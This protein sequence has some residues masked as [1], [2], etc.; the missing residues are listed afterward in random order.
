MKSKLISVLTLAILLPILGFAQQRDSP[1]NLLPYA[2]FKGNPNTK[3]VVLRVLG[4]S[5]Q[6]GEIPAHTGASAYSHL[7]SVYRNNVKGS[8]AEIDDLLQALGYSGFNDP[9]F[10]A[11]SLLPEILPAGTIGWMGAYNRKHKYAW[12]SLGKAFPTFKIYSKGG[13]CFLYIMKKCG[14]AFY[15]PTYDTTPQCPA[16]LSPCPCPAG[17]RC[18][19]NG[20]CELIPPPPTACKTQTINISGTGQVSSGDVMSTS[21]SMELIAVNTS[22][23]GTKGLLLGS[24]PVSVRSIYDFNVKGEAKYSKNVE[25]CVLATET[26][27]PMNFALPMNLNYKITKNEVVV[28][29]GEK[30]YLNVDDAQFA[31]LSKAYKAVNVATTSSPNLE[32]ATKKVTGS[33]AT[34]SVQSASGGTQCADQKINF[35]GK[36]QVQ[37]G[38]VK[39]ATN[40][41]TIIGVYKKAGKLDKGETPEKYLCLGSFQVP[42]K[43]AYEFT[44]SGGSDVSKLVR[45]C[46][47]DGVTPADMNIN[48]PVNMTYN[49][50]KQDVVLGDYNKLYVQLNEKQYKSLSK[51]YNRCCTVGGEGKACK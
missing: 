3:P 15:I 2:I 39:S 10:S 32:V 22:S 11:K 38:S 6:F 8:K 41:V 35:M 1:C 5:P 30:L 7:K 25:V 19:E 28:G 17:Y 33:S 37:D 16:G 24:Y 49:F 34:E 21:K 36:T 47:K 20:C 42:V 31:A 51:N 40:D 4:T 26:P 29:D 14:N 27:V 9:A 45:V 46:T 50:T 13:D 12:S 48:V 23:K 43:S 18:N 44:T